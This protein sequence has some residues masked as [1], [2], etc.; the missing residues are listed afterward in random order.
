MSFFFFLASHDGLLYEQLWLQLV[1]LLFPRPYISTWYCNIFCLCLS[2]LHVSKQQRGNVK[3]FFLAHVQVI[4]PHKAKEHKKMAYKK[5]KVCRFP[6]FLWNVRKTK[7]KISINLTIT[8][9][10][11]W[12]WWS[13][14]RSWWNLRRCWKW[15]VVCFFFLSLSVYFF[16]PLVR[17]KVVETTV[18]D[19]SL[20]T[21]KWQQ[22]HL[23]I[24]KVRLSVCPCA[25]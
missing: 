5:K 10:W 1:I 23:P 15:A 11:W 19:S 8:K 6:R 17:E 22:A 21:L 9:W 2:T 14:T 3:L 13:H 20:F 25:R 12:L 24:L 18:I 7:K 16:A 4:I